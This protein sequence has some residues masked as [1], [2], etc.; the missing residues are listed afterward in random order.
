LRASS[1]RLAARSA[2]SSTSRPLAAS[3]YW[4]RPWP[5]LC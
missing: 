4:L 5:P 2:A 1:T 3:C